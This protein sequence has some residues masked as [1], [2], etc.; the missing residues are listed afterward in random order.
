MRFDFT[1]RLIFQGTKTNACKVVRVNMGFKDERRNRLHRSKAT[2]VVKTERERE[3]EIWEQNVTWTLALSV[4][5]P[6]STKTFENLETVANGAAIFRKRFQEIWKLLNFR[7]AN[8]STQN[9][10]NSGS[11]VEW[12][13]N[14]REKKFRKFG[15]TSWGCP[16]FW[17]FWKKLFHSLLEVA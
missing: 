8:H 15:Y 3:S 14:F 17:K 13:E 6:H 10:R 7:N 12:K 4:T 5:L 9:S 1:S 11:K 16:L 2:N